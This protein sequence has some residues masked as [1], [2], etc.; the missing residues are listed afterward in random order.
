MACQG[1]LLRDNPVLEDDMGREI[2]DIVLEL[3]ILK[4]KL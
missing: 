3:T 4:K 2:E 1:V